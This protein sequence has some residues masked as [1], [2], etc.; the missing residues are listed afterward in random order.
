MEMF[1]FVALIAAGFVALALALKAAFWVVAVVVLPLFWLWM[2]VDA[3]IRPAEEY[4]TKTANEK[5]LWIVLMT[6]AVG[7]GPAPRGVAGTLRR[8][9]TAVAR[10]PAAVRRGVAVR[11]E[12]GGYSAGRRLCA[13]GAKATIGLRRSLP[14][15][16]RL[17]GL[18]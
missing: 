10:D 6:I 3:I 7:A 18:A 12:S 4:P 14:S 17:G 11:F 1:A 16:A 8:S 5:I 9:A 15:A 13:G 2:L